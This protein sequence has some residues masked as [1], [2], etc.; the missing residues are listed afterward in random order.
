M[1]REEH[2]AVKNIPKAVIA[3]TDHGIQAEVDK[4][5][6]VESEKVVGPVA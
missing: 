4:A 2:T 3:V 1:Q 6:V 5:G